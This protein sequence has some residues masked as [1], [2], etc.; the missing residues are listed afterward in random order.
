MNTDQI[1]FAADNG[2]R[3]GSKSSPR[4]G[5]GGGGEGEQKQRHSRSKISPI[6]WDKSVSPPSGE[7]KG[8]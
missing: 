6:K 5:G 7:R 8:L 4:G 3:A 2:K 1:L